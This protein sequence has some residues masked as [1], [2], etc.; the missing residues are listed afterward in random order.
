MENFTLIVE[1]NSDK[2]IIESILAAAKMGKHVNVV[3]GGSKRETEKLAQKMLDEDITNLGMLI[4]LDI[5]NLPDAKNYI[6]D[7]KLKNKGIEV[8]F[9]APEIEAWLF[10]DMDLA[11]ENARSKSAKTKIILRRMP[12]PD[13]IPH[14]K[15]SANYLFD[16]YKK[17]YFLKKINV[18]KAASRS[19]SLHDFLSRMSAILNIQLEELKEPIS[20]NI[21][22]KIFVNLLNETTHSD[23]VI[24]KSSSGVYTTEQMIENIKNETE[25]GKQY[26]SDLLRIARDLLMR[27]ANRK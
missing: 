2:I 4:D 8:F 17:P 19:P 23:K 1:G 9:A 22:R 18:S 20:Q 25:L 3:V 5:I 6:E 7:K 16:N 26:T 10:A 11:L 24:F 12:L 13:E 27:Q 15:Q 21:D 14:P